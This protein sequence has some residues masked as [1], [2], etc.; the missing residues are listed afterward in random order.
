M[1]LKLNLMKFYEFHILYFPRIPWNTFLYVFY[2]R[3]ILNFLGNLYLNKGNSNK[4][5]QKSAK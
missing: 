4:T 2:S 1:C 3:F 5:M